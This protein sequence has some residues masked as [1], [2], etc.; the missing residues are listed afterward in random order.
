M[1]HPGEFVEYEPNAAQAHAAGGGDGGEGWVSG[2]L[3]WPLMCETLN[4]A[5]E[6]VE[7]VSAR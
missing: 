7:A 3:G 4:G 1:L 5:V 2:I 6:A